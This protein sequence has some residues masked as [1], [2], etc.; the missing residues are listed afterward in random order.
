M[1]AS[2][3]TVDQTKFVHFIVPIGR[4]G[5]QEEWMDG[6]F[7]FIGKRKHLKKINN[8]FSK[9][10]TKKGSSLFIL[11]ICEEIFAIFFRQNI[12]Y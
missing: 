6:E 5:L 9:I 7:F 12:L 8:L 3:G 2:P 11:R 1:K 4:I 10:K